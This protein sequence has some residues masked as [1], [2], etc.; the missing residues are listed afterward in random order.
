MR[1]AM[2]A[3]LLESVP[4]KAYG[5]TERV[6]HYLT[7]GL[8]ER[9]HDVTLFA[10]GDSHTRADLVSI[11]RESLRLS[12][13]K[14]DP[15]IYHTRQLMEVV[16]MVH[17]FDIVHFH[18]DYFHFPAWRH[19]TTPQVMTTHGRLDIADLK[20]IYDEFSEMALV[21]ISDSQRKPLPKAGWVATVYNGTPA[22]TFTFRNAPGDYL[23]FLGRFTPEKGPEEAIQIAKRVGMPLKMAAKIDPLDRQY[24]AERIEPLLDDPMIEF[25]GEADDTTKNELLGGARALLFPIAWPEPFGLVM[26]EA[27]A[28]GTPVIAFRNGSVDEVM[29][30]KMTGFVVDT[31]DEAV[32][33]VKNI[34][35]ISRQQCRKHFQ[36]KFTAERMVQNYLKV[37][38]KLINAERIEPVDPQADIVNPVSLS[39][40]SK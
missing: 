18:S 38:E 22:D 8:V 2:V 37:Y 34:H 13:T 36:S 17:H 21:S 6:V 32:E 12:K 7:E 4:P 40:R 29:V 31:I 11:C 30:D 15:A 9:G 26:T 3:P 5:G 25:I 28:C 33:A 14:H 19:I 20:I 35:M 1:I 39:S 24:F 27:M 10:S 16:R 23:A